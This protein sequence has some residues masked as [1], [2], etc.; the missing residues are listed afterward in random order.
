MYKTAIIIILPVCMADYGSHLALRP[1]VVGAGIMALCSLWSLWLACLGCP[2]FPN[3]SLKLM[4]LGIVIA[5][6]NPKKFEIG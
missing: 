5:L 1:S 6:K 4:S 2:I 3:V